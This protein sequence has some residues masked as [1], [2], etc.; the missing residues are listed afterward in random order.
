MKQK[1][2]RL[3]IKIIRN[4][5]TIFISLILL[6][7]LFFLLV[8][9]GVFGPLPNKKELSSI[10]NEEASLVYSSDGKL[11]GK[12][13]A[14]N[15]TNI[16]WEEVPDHLK[17]ALIATEDKRFFSHKGY[18]TRSYLRVFLK[19]ILLGDR[20]GGG[21]ST[22]TQQLAKN[23]YGRSDFGFLSIP[24]N[25]IREIILAARLEAVYS[26]EELLLLYLNSVPFGEDVYGVESASHRFF[27]KSAHELSV[28]ESAVLIA[29][30]KANTYF[31]PRLNPANSLQRRNLVLDLMKN[32][33]YLSAK[34]ADSLKKLPL[35]IH[36]DNLNSKAP[37]GYFVYQVKKKALDILEQI[38]YDSGIE[39]NL[40]KDG[41]KIV[42]TMNL[43]VQNMAMESVKKQLKQMQP[44]LD[45]E[46][47][48]QHFK[49]RWIKQF[50]ESEQKSAAR[51][52]E[53]FGWD[54]M[55]TKSMSP[56]DSLWHYHKMLNAAVLVT[57]PKDGS[58]IAWI[59]GNNF[60]S[61]P[62]DMVLSH[63]Q[64]ASAFKPVLYATAIEAGYSPCE[65][66]ENEEKTYPE[67]DD[68]A[69]ENANHLSTPDSTVA[70]WY[71]LANSMNLPTVDLYFKVGRENL[72]RIC[73]RLHFPSI[74][75]DSPSIALG[76]LDL[77]LEEIVRTYGAFAN[78]G[79]MNELVMINKISDARG[80]VLYRRE[81][82]ESEEVFKPETSQTI[83]AMLQTAINQGT[84]VKIREQYRIQ[85]DLAGKT[86]TAQ[87]YSDAWFMAYT[88]DLVVGTWVGASTP[89]IH[90]NSANGSGSSLALPIVANVIRGIERNS[91]LR[92]RY[93]TPFVIPNEIYASMDCEPYQQS[94]IKGF[95]QRLF[96]S[97][98]KIENDTLNADSKEEGTVKSFF[99]KLFKRKKK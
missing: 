31:N 99:K 42:T 86:G 79:Q 82:A 29:M 75:E 92:R 88:P 6:G 39:Y 26:K 5:I 62:F 61:L 76:T 68:W 17:N 12:Y 45:R 52:V 90:F 18:D 14:E 81:Y 24:V 51:N 36:Y 80:N 34:E 35:T 57:N 65:Y 74:P 37:A 41:L 10:R 8:Y 69:P 59:G 7:A 44:L 64:I 2:K 38:K 28:E 95:F 56:L 23:L 27:D 58:V 70:L 55:E 1:N 96:S 33:H 20:S 32:E 49:R 50:P 3:F 94:G 98:D 25:K 22:L 48:R 11:I 87:N 16:S 73:R 15:R 91:E 78:Q 13:F 47:E 66:L 97:D 53:V 30:L 63:R 67:Y 9:S 60:N 83:T 85:A 71:A 46:L 93:L 40:E 72:L 89:D 19:S 77:S 54:G 84:G 4:S 43:Q 21:G